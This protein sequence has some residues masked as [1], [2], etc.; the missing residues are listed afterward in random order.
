MNIVLSGRIDSSNAPD[1]EK[2]IW[3]KLKEGD[4]T[5]D[6]LESIRTEITDF[7][8]ASPAPAAPEEA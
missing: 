2:K 3:E 1:W 7:I 8:K 5:P 6:L 4:F